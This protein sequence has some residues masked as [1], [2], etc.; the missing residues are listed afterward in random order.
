MRKR[1][2]PVKEANGDY[3]VID[4][5][6]RQSFVYAKD[7]CKNCYGRGWIGMSEGCTECLG[8]GEK[9]GADC[10]KC[11]GTGKGKEGEKYHFPCPCLKHEFEDEKEEYI[12]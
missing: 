12:D 7:N 8:E 10:A 11:K 4:V 6:G 1:Y 5:K 2:N 9:N 3:V